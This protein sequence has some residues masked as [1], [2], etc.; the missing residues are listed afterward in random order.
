VEQADKLAFVRWL[1]KPGRSISKTSGKKQNSMD[2][3]SYCSELCYCFDHVHL[4]HIH[5][6]GGTEDFHA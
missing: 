3:V 4:L 5:V 2:F 6:S 1:S